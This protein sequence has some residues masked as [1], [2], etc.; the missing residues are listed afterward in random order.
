MKKFIYKKNIFKLFFTIFCFFGF[1]ALS[2]SKISAAT[3]AFNPSSKSFEK[4]CERSINID[5]D[6]SGQSSNAVDVE[7]SFDPSKITILDSDPGTAGVQIKP[8]N[9]Y[10][11]TL[12]NSVNNTT[13]EILFAAGSFASNLTSK[14]VLATIE[15]ISSDTLNNAEFTF[16]YTGVGNT[17]DSNIAESSTS[18]DI[19][20][21]VVNGNYSFI[22]GLCEADTTAP[23]VTFISPKKGQK[24]FPV[25]NNV[26]IRVT[27]DQSG[28][29]LDTLV[30]FINGVEYKV[31]DPQVIYSGDLLNYIFT[32]NPDENFPNDQ[33]A[34]NTILG[35]DNAGNKFN[36]SMTFNVPTIE[37]PPLLQK[38]KTPPTVEF[39]SPN[40]YDTNV[41]PNS[42]IRFK[43]LDEESGIDINSLVFSINGDIYTSSSSGVTITGDLH[44]YFVSIDP[45]GELPLDTYIL[46]NIYGTDL[47]GNYFEQDL[48]FNIPSC[49]VPTE[50]EVDDNQ[51]C[52]GDK[53]DSNEF[54]DVARKFF[55]DIDN[56]EVFK[57]TIFEGTVVDK[58][59]N[60]IGF[61]GSAALLIFFILLF[62]ILSFL[63]LI[64]TPG[65]F[66]GALDIIKSKRSKRPWGIVMDASTGKPLPFATC[67]LY[68]SDSLSLVMQSVSD[69]DGKYGFVVGSGQ[70]RLEVMRPGFEKFIKNI[71]IG[72]NERTYVFDVKL[73]PSD[74]VKQKESQIKKILKPLKKLYSKISPFLFIIGFLFSIFSVIASRH[75]INIIIIIIYFGVI[76]F[77]IYAKLRRRGKYASVI[78]AGNGYK[79]PFA[80][81]KIFNL[82][83]YELIETI[84]TNYIGQFD[85]W[86]DPGE[87]GIL[88]T[89]RGYKFPSQKNQFPLVEKEFYG[90]VKV[91]LKQGKNEIDLYMDPLRES[92][93]KTHKKE[94]NN[95][96]KTIE[97]EKAAKNSTLSEM[98][99]N[100]QNNLDSPFN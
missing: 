92:S 41:D 74:L 75:L 100:T 42:S 50:G 70:Y 96:Q 43:I 52:I 22:S 34:T 62:N 17:L 33:A 84:S 56:V 6:V 85:Y 99:N 95:A 8:G 47:E 15:F 82:E 53:V 61:S 67:R 87:Y 60:E 39:I 91:N 7:I 73:T 45:E 66:F 48:V 57:G 35:K 94:K 12:V 90:M 24:N 49:V 83:N 32:I 26:V 10:E 93:V 29:N 38:D 44:E 69:L 86:G 23:I 11:V 63:P 79:I 59:T 14:R 37:S 27:D 81:I 40:D 97:Q 68:I 19:L 21:G 78:D 89:K 13:G 58:L 77:L 65:M 30:F 71:K 16:N 64:S 2:N 76:T 36:K 80:Q 98:P 88:V 46:V 72:Q 20:S 1:F 5:I 9:A 28:I 25:G 18:M 3:L 55:T 4:G 54:G 31:T 51:N